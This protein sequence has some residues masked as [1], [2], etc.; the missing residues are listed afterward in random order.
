[1]LSRTRVV[2]RRIL[3]APRERDAP[4]VCHYRD[5]VDIIDIVRGW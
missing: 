2:A 3:G 4:K 5:F 1:M